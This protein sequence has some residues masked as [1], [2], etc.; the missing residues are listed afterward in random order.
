MTIR[1]VTNLL[2][3]PSPY[4]SIRCQIYDSLLIYIS[5]DEIETL[6]STGYHLITDLSETTL[7]V[8]DTPRPTLKLV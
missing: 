5:D 2:I 3:N 8:L 4:E 6:I 7:L 1:S